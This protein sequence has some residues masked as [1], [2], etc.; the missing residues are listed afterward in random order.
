M[1]CM[2]NMSCMSYISIFTFNFWWGLNSQL[3]PQNIAQPSLQQRSA[4]RNLCFGVKCMNAISNRCKTQCFRNSTHVKHNVL[5]APMSKTHRK[6]TTFTSKIIWW[7]SCVVL[8]LLCAILAP[9]CHNITQD[10]WK[11]ITLEP[12]SSNIAPQT[13][14][15]QVATGLKGSA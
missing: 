15:R 7:L 11:N 8:A 4:Y 14:P 10:R 6:I 12:T 1:P 5:E 13:R 2:S 3:N 9:R